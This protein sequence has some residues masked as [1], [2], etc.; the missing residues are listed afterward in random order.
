MGDFWATDAYF[1]LAPWRHRIGAQ[2]LLHE[3]FTALCLSHS[4]QSPELQTLGHLQHCLLPINLS[5]VSVGSSYQA[6]KITS[7]FH[8]VKDMVSYISTTEVSLVH[9]STHPTFTEW[10][11]ESRCS[12]RIVSDTFCVHLCTFLAFQLGYV[13]D[14]SSSFYS[15]SSLV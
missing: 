6:L 4:R 9:R 13:S 12:E 1:L 10:I 15:L 5:L 7:E 2:A 11:R 14:Y 8:S 3:P